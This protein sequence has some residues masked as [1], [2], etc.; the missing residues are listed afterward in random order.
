MSDEPITPDENAEPNFMAAAEQAINNL[1]AKAEEAATSAEAA[2]AAATRAEKSAKRWKKLTLVLA[3]FIALS[4]V[5]GGVTGYYVNQARD[6]ANSLRQQSISSCIAGNDLRTQLD[7]L[8]AKQG[9]ASSQVTETAI[10][11]FIVVLEGKNP[12]KSVL[13]IAESLEKQIKHSADT[14]QAEFKKALDKATTP[15]NCEQAFE[16]TTGNGANPQSGDTQAQFA[17]VT[18]TVIQLRSWNGGC[19]TAATA[20]IGAHISEVACGSAHNWVYGSNGQMSLQGH[21]DT[22]AGDSGG[23]LVLRA[24]GTAT[25]SDSAKAGP[26]GFTYDRLFFGPANTYWHANGDGHNVTLISNPGSSLAVYYAF[27]N[28][29]LNAA[30]PGITAV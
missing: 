25:V 2:E 15:R 11:E 8:L 29:G 30:V 16:N 4:L 14:T 23:N 18:W 13:A 3:F 9:A 22:A 5:V 28:G 12:S 1:S 7:Q 19:L 6:N 26:S 21:T 10:H 20:S 27:L 17:A 24:P